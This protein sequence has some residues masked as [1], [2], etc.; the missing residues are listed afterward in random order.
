MSLHAATK[1]FVAKRFAMTFDV[2]VITYI[3][4]RILYFIVEISIVFPTI[5][6]SLA[7]NNNYHNKN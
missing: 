7:K 4:Q 5:L 3:S 1:T 6:L 2:A